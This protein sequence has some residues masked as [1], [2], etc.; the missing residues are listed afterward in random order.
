MQPQTIHANIIATKIP[1]VTWS[2]MVP[3]VA[4]RHCCTR[5][6][7]AVTWFF[8]AVGE[9]STVMVAA[10]RV[11]SAWHRPSV[12]GGRVIGRRHWRDRRDRRSRPRCRPA[13]RGDGN[14]CSFYFASLRLLRRTRLA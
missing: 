7:I 2:R 1:S 5:K 8:D 9:I 10:R 13:K 12:L 4:H 3:S 14:V 11:E 6:N